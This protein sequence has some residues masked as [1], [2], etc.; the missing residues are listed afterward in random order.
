M[1]ARMRNTPVMVFCKQDGQGGI[2]PFDLLDEL[3]KE[4]KIAICPYTCLLVTESS[5]KVFYN[6]HKKIS[7]FLHPIKTSIFRKALSPPTISKIRISG[8]CRSESINK[9]LEEIDFVDD[10]LKPSICHFTGKV[11]WPSV[12]LE[13]P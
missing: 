11:T 3:E 6:L 1:S 13:V 8:F 4:L 2:N 12:F 9:L 10:C 5:L 7:R